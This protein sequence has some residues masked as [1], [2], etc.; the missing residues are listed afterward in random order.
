MI[1]LL[2]VVPDAIQGNWVAPSA[3]VGSTTQRSKG[4]AGRWVAK[5]CICIFDVLRR[6]FF[7]TASC[8]RFVLRRRPSKKQ[9]TF[10]TFLLQGQMLLQQNSNGWQNAKNDIPK[11][12][13]ILRKTVPKHI[14]SSR[15][16]GE[17][18]KVANRV[19][20]HEI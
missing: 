10:F 6:F 12:K 8:F 3:E 20:S 17:R 5:V 9:C 7:T 1:A 19:E 16:K 14:C 18:N 13:V 11:I 4:R 15:N 2:H